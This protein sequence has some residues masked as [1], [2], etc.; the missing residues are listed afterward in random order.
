MYTSEKE[1]LM[2]AQQTLDNLSTFCK[3]DTTD[4]HMWNGKAATYHWNRG[5]DTASGLING[6][7]RKLAG[8]D[9][10]GTQIWVVA[11]SFKI[12]PDGAILRF[13]G[14]PKSVQKQLSTPVV[15]PVAQNDTVTV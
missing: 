11:G 12:A 4:T 6:V 13:T 7:V 10:G 3:T 2:S 14:L 1:K 8:I 15:V 9:A 5:K